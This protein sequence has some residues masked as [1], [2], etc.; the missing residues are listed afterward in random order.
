MKLVID[1]NVIISALLKKS[2]TREILLF[3]SFEFFL[4]EYALEE[5]EAHRGAIPKRSGLSAEEIDLLLSV[6]L[7]NITIVPSA[8]IKPHIA[9]ADKLIGS[10]DRLDIPFVALALSVDNDGIWSNDK[11]F[12]NIKEITVWK[13]ADILN[14]IDKETEG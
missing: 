9:K 2:V 8:E 10:R 7:E 14:F 5:V 1:T 6:I 3:P 13:T 12:G 4:P 11:H